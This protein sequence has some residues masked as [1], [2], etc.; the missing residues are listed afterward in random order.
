MKLYEF[1]GKELFRKFGIRTPK[2][3][4]C[5]KDAIPSWSG[6]CVL[7]AQTLSGGRGKAGA[8][9][10]CDAEAERDNALKKLFAMTLKD[11]PVNAVLI[12]E[13]VGI[14]HEYY[15]SVAFDGEA[16]TP[17]L[18]VSAS[19]GMDIEKVADEHPELIL[20]LPFDSIAGPQEYHFQRAA[21]FAGV[22]RTRD[23][24]ALLSSL[25][26][27]YRETC[28]S[29][30]EV[31]PLV[32]TADGFIALDA[33][34]ELDDDA[35]P[36]NKTLCLELQKQ[37]REICGIDAKTGRSGDGHADFGPAARQRR[38]SCELL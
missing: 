2:G 38:Q 18:I 29:L 22:S 35:E 20:R 34:V 6:P 5:K 1:Q 32:E 17:L 16:G 23:F 3:I 28:A 7:K 36:L 33:K 4:I 21:K 19:G 9:L 25:Y 37:Q 26:T 24:S 14:L 13:R 15:F 11:E 27:V 8:V 12:E 10:L 30:V 31:N